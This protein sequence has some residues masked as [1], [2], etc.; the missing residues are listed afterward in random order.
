MD[1][2]KRYCTFSLKELCVPQFQGL[3]LALENLD[4]QQC[5]KISQQ[6][7][8]IPFSYWSKTCDCLTNNQPFLPFHQLSLL[9]LEYPV[10]SKNDTVLPSHLLY[11]DE[12][13]TTCCLNDLICEYVITLQVLH[14]LAFPFLQVFLA[15]QGLPQSPVTKQIQKHMKS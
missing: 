8:T 2:D 14:V 4:H 6:V 10:E 13:F 3:H 12:I 7:S 1:T 11:R 9:A 15:H 5:P